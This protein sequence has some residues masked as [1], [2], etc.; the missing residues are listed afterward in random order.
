MS[1]VNPENLSVI[2]GHSDGSRISVASYPSTGGHGDKA[3]GFQ[4]EVGVNYFSS[5][6]S[7]SESGVV[8]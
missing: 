3:R 2:V 4:K 8:T 5:S 6:W 7:S 1:Q